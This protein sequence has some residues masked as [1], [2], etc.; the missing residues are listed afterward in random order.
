[1]GRKKTA[2]QYKVLSG[3]GVH[4]PLGPSAGRGQDGS[5]IKPNKRPSMLLAYAMRKEKL[6]GSLIDHGMTPFERRETDLPS[7]LSPSPSP[8][9]SQPP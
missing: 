4:G 8:P 9:I 7:T 5:V 2:A 1:M 3:E 6:H